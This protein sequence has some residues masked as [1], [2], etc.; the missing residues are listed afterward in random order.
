M[1]KQES[2][3]ELEIIQREEKEILELF[4]NTYNRRKRSIRE[5]NFD[6]LEAWIFRTIERIKCLKGIRNRFV[7]LT[8][9]SNLQSVYLKAYE[10]RKVKGE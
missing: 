2:K 1:N 5:V 10:A 7:G 4:D 6:T 9:K 8:I 3:Q